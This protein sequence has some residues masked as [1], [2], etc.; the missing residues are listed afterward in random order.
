MQCVDAL[1]IGAW[2][3]TCAGALTLLYTTGFY[4]D[5]QIC[6][7]AIT[8]CTKSHINTMLM[9]NGNQLNSFLLDYFSTFI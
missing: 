6:Y 5:R 7:I 8:N 4:I 1:S 9:F 2:R 3:R